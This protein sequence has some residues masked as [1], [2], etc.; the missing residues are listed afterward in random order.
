MITSYSFTLIKR[1]T[2]LFGLEKYP[3]VVMVRDSAQQ[4]ET[5]LKVPG[6]PYLAY[7]DRQRRLQ[8]VILGE[9]DLGTLRELVAN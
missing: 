3:N 7:Y 2:K 6:I 9:V 4:L 5:Y 1:Y 8:K